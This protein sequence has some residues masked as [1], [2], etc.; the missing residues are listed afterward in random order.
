[1]IL[2]SA[3]LE[4]YLVPL[5]ERLGVDAVV[6][7]RLERDAHGRLTG[8]LRGANCRGA[9]KARRAH[10]WLVGAGL[11]DAELWAYGDSP[12]DAELLAAADHPVRVDGV[13]ITEDPG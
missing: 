9:E 5:G 3:S 1:V 4:Q 2:A 8:R 6:C 7:T 12:G 13:S 10:E 11:V